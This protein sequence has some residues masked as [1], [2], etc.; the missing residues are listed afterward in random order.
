[1]ILQKNQINILEY[2]AN[3]LECTGIILTK[4]SSEQLIVA[5]QCSKRAAAF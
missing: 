4:K 3:F 5:D 2:T 1:M